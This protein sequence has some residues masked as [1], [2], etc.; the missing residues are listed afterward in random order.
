MRVCRTQ[1]PPPPPPPPPPAPHAPPDAPPASSCSLCTTLVAGGSYDVWLLAEDSGPDALPA[2]AAVVLRPNAQAAPLRLSVTTQSGLAPAFSGGTPAVLAAALAGADVS[3]ALSSSGTVR[4]VVVLGVAGATPQPSPEQVAAGVG[5]DGAAAAASGTVVLRAAGVAVTQRVSLL[6]LASRFGADFSLFAY[7]SGGAEDASLVSA[8]ATLPLAT[9]HL[10]PPLWRFLSVTGVRNDA[11]SASTAFIVETQ[12]DEPCRIFYVVI[13]A[14]AAAS[15]PPT[16]LQVLLAANNSGVGLRTA[17]AAAWGAF[18]VSAADVP[19]AFT[20]GDAGSGGAL[21]DGAGYKL[22]AVARD[23]ASNASPMPEAVA[24]STPPGSAPLFRGGGCSSAALLSGG[25]ACATPPWQRSAVPRL[26]SVSED[27]SGGA[28]F[29]LVAA[30]DAPGILYFMLTGGAPDDDPTRLQLLAATPYTSAAGTAVAPLAARGVTLRAGEVARL[31]L[32]APSLPFAVFVATATTDM[33]LL[34]DGS[35]AR[36]NRTAVTKLAPAVLRA[37]AAAAAAPDVGFGLRVALSAPGRVSYVVLRAG[38]PAPPASRVLLGTDAAGRS[39]GDSLSAFPLGATGALAGALDVT[40]A[41]TSE[42]GTLI[43]GVAPRTKLDVYLVTQ[44]DAASDVDAD[45]GAYGEATRGATV[46]FALAAPP[47]APPGF[48]AG[49]PALSAL[50]SPTRVA[51]TAVL[52]YA[53]SRVCALALLAAATAPNTTEILAGGVCARVGT[54]GAAATLTLTGLSPGAAHT[55]Y[56]AADDASIPAGAWEPLPPSPPVALAFTAPPLAPALATLTGTLADGT[57]VALTQGGTA[58]FF[59]VADK[60]PASA[61]LLNISAEGSAAETLL[62]LVSG[63]STWSGVAALSAQWPLAAGANRATLTVAAGSAAD[64]PRVIYRL[65][66]RRAAASADADDATLLSLWAVLPDGTALNASC[67]AGRAWPLLC[68]TPPCARGCGALA[69]AL[70]LPSSAHNISLVA[71]PRAAAAAVRVLA[72][73]AVGSTAA[74]PGWAVDVD[75]ARM[76]LQRI[77]ALTVVVTAPDGVAMATYRVA[78]LREGPGVYPGWRPPAVAARVPG[79]MLPAAESS[80][81]W[82]ALPS[83]VEPL[84]FQPAAA[85]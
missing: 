13:P 3:F 42:L 36:D 5:G 18:D 77:P 54:A 21:L 29:T 48:A 72:G 68:S 73:D 38:A 44:H 25:G 66:V 78:L 30:L 9:P 51:L 60:L 23:A 80:V 46:K 49:S 15:V 35:T 34:G 27:G 1:P 56:L 50:L 76:A 74:A 41:T 26:E 71:L 81:T 31:P 40:D 58:L 75:T 63:A 6:P 17:V 65:Y 19:V 7:A 85:E 52:D 64:A 16:A 4:Y 24:F 70:T 39:P 62:S 33:A 37:T 84:T 22:F 47:A 10:L 57:A 20:H 45:G 28:A 79:Q 59:S 8:L 12:L 83:S 32:T 11:A 61:V 69:G 67:A 82:G 43:S 2:A 53:P 55:A 14:E